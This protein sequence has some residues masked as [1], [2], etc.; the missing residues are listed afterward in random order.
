MNLEIEATAS[1]VH[2]TIDIQ[3]QHALLLFV[4]LFSIGRIKNGRGMYLKHSENRHNS[5]SN[6][7]VLLYLYCKHGLDFLSVK[8]FW[9]LVKGNYLLFHGR[10][11]GNFILGINC[12][13][14]SMKKKEREM[15]KKWRMC[16]VIENPMNPKLSSIK[17]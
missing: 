8:C 1:G 6:K 9:C 17:L 5:F 4:D 7:A 13:A 16:F 12:Y 3:Q 11:W 2:C 10:T 15:M 14:R